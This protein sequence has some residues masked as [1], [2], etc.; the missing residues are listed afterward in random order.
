[1]RKSAALPPAP[2]KKA[3]KLLDGKFEVGREIGAGGMGVVYFGRDRSLD[4][5]VA[6]KRMRE[7]IRWDARER[8]RFIAEA[9]LV[10]R[11]KHPHIVEI[12]T[13]VEQDGEVYL[14][15]EFI[16]GQTLMESIAQKKM[17][18]FEKARDLFRGVASAL[19]FAHGSGVIHRDLKPGN[20]MVDSEG[21]V[22]IMD[23]GIARLTE[24]AVSRHSK[25]KSMVGT[26]LDMAPEQEQG[27][28]RKESDVY[29][30]AICLYESLTGRTPF[31][32]IGTGLL[33]NKLKS[34]PV[35]PSRH[36]AHLP[37]GLDQV[38]AKALDPD[39][40][41][42]YTSAGNLMR[43]LEGLETPRTA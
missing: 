20:L 14:V 26:P 19:D 10:A 16:P 2:L 8:E 9:R 42:R 27:V 1:M 5:V 28:A 39:P 33:M 43:A 41:K 38:F 32:G 7:E 34:A 23:F 21:R 24:E 15:F 13:I 6:I 12:H 22:R 3:P 35:P 40:A 30:M 31:S 11:L 29:S 17:L 18:P 25:T 36:N 4:R 37:A